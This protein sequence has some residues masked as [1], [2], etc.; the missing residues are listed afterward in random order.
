MGFYWVFTGFDW[1]LLSFAEFQRGLPGLTE[2]YRFFLQFH[3]I[4]T[5][6]FT[7]SF[8][9]MSPSFSTISTQWSRG[10]TEFERPFRSM[11][12]S[13]KS[14]SLIFGLFFWEF[15]VLKKKD[16]SLNNIALQWRLIRF[17]TCSQFGNS[18]TRQLEGKSNK[19][20]LF[21][22]KLWS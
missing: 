7:D 22:A 15:F 11:E 13:R 20:F 14:R 21:L 6:S 3:H 8:F 1:V 10:F 5:G 16:V 12:T 4:S 17:A 19:D 9:L 2:F 18:A